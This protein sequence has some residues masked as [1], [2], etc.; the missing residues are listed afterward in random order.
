[1]SIM[2]KNNW[3]TGLKQHF[4]HEGSSWLA[5]STTKEQARPVIWIVQRTF[6]ERLLLPADTTGKA[7]IPFGMPG[8]VKELWLLKVVVAGALE[9]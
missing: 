5:G 2:Y 1:M 9:A 4:Q 8:I 3:S 7:E 6:Q